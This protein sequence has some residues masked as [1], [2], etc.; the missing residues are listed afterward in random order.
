MLWVRTWALFRLSGTKGAYSD[1]SPL[2]RWNKVSRLRTSNSYVSS[3]DMICCQSKLAIQSSGRHWKEKERL[4][5]LASQK[6]ATVGQSL[7]YSVDTVNEMKR[8]HSKSD[9]ALQMMQSLRWR[10]TLASR[11]DIVAPNRISD[12]LRLWKCMPKDIVDHDGELLWYSS[13]HMRIPMWKLRSGKWS[14]YVQCRW[15]EF[16]QGPVA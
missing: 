15:D 9:L 7:W 14:G 16:S 10:A 1:L 6:V 13:A 12:Y 5:K 4:R 8:A 3:R 11:Y 2:S